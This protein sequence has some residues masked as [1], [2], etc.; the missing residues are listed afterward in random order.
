MSSERSVEYLFG[1]YR[2]EVAERVG[3]NSHLFGPRQMLTA[4]VM[5][6]VFNTL[7]TF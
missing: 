3:L 7:G 2:E 4:V 5:P 6:L 1:L